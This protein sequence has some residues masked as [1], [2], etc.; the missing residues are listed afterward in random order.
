MS[1]VAAALI[2]IRG[3]KSNAKVSMKTEIASAT[4]H[5]QDESLDRLRSAERDLRA[6]GRITGEIE[7]LSSAE[8]GVRVEA[9]LAEQ[10]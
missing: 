8:A 10:A 1:D 7:W 6:V 3:A 4:V 5:A 2:G 9:D